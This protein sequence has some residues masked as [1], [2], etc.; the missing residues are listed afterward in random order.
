MSGDDRRVRFEQG[1]VVVGGSSPPVVTAP[2]V[3]HEHGPSKS[4]G[5]QHGQGLGVGL[6]LLA[7]SGKP[8]GQQGGAGLDPY[9]T[10]VLADAPLAYWRLAERSGTLV[11]DSSGNGVVGTYLNSP[12]LGI[13]GVPGTDGNT[14]ASFDSPIG[15]STPY[16]ATFGD[17]LPLTGTALS[18]ELWIKHGANLDSPFSPLVNRGNVTWRIQTGNSGANLQFAVGSGGTPA[19]TAAPAGW[20]DATAWHHVVGVYTRASLIL[21]FDGV[22]AASKAWSTDVP[23]SPGKSVGIAFNSEAP[24]AFCH[25]LIDEV[26]IYNT[27]LSQARITAHYNAGIA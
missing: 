20:P 2:P 16:Q 23:S 15:T 3:T 1:R 7:G 22:A 5:P 21:Y 12:P 19:V 27:A 11:G 10:T 26:A 14:A 17:V 6:A 8:P 24:T 18:I 25:D 13:P 4:Q 9:A